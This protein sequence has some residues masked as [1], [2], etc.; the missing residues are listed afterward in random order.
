MGNFG[1]SIGNQ[2]S[3]FIK[4]LL[5]EFIIK[6]NTDEDF[7]TKWFS[8]FYNNKNYLENREERLSNV[9]KWQKKHKNLGALDTVT[10]EQIAQFVAKNLFGLTKLD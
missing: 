4:Y 6:C 10:R 2:I 3:F 1:I 9:I 7:T 8:K 5:E